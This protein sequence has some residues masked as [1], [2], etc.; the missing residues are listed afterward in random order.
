MKESAGYL[1]DLTEKIVLKLIRS[2]A[3][4]QCACQQINDE[5]CKQQPE[6]GGY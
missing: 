5:P 4:L 2:A 1:C 6:D 3:I